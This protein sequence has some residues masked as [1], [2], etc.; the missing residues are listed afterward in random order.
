MRWAAFGGKRIGLLVRSRA[1]SA[2]AVI[3]SI[4]GAL[5][6]GNPYLD[7]FEAAI[8][9]QA[10]M[11]AHAHGHAE[12]EFVPFASATCRNSEAEATY[13]HRGRHF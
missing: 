9:F 11:I 3:N 2:A 13:R 6:G 10:P 1:R 4:R 5:R 8:E 12:T 7:A